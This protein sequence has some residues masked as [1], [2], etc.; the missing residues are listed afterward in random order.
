MPQ[1]L[2]HGIAVGGNPT[3][4]L[5]T[6]YEPS[7]EFG[8]MPLYRAVCGG[9]AGMYYRGESSKWILTAKYS[10]EIALRAGA[11]WHPIPNVD[12]VFTFELPVYQ[13]VNELQPETDFRVI[14]GFGYRF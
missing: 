7:G 13:D 12:V 9:E 14:A 10:E 6:V 11:T 4:S 5:N 3:A 1:S 2:E 8:G